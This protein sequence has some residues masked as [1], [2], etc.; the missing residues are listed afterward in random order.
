MAEVISF[1]KSNPRMADTPS[2]DELAEKKRNLK[3]N[4]FRD[5]S[6]EIV[7]NVVRDI[8]ALE[9]STI[10]GTEL[11]ELN[12]KDIIILREALL[13]IMCRLTNMEHPLHDIIKDLIIAEEGVD[14]YGE[15][16]YGYTL[17]G[18]GEEEKK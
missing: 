9:L 2:V 10:A 8:A 16:M 7:E 18:F 13:S 4:F 5:M 11:A 15:A 1:P 17:R 12:A 14:E 6:D 3:L